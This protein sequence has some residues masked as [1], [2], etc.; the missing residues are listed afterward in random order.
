MCPDVQPFQAIRTTYRHS[1]PLPPPPRLSTYTRCQPKQH[2]YTH[3]DTHTDTTRNGRSPFPQVPKFLISLTREAI[4]SLETS[5]SSSSP[6]LSPSPIVGADTVR[7]LASAAGLSPSLSAA[8]EAAWS[9]AAAENEEGASLPGEQKGFARERRVALVR[10][11]VG[12]RPGE[13]CTLVNGRR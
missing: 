4:L 9:S 1:P 7:R 8:V 10:E 3:T 13:P 12:L 2:T 6:S 5:T 11:V